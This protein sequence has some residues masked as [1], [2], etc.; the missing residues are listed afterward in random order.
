[1]V[2]KSRANRSGVPSGMRASQLQEWLSESRKAEAAVI[3]VS[4]TAGEMEGGMATAMEKEKEAETK[5]GTDA[6]K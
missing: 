2:R 3:S 6:Y 1:M 4:D 5:V